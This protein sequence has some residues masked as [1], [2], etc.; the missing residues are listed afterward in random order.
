MKEIQ[1]K[2][3]RQ[4]HRGTEQAR[5]K[6][7]NV[8]EICKAI[9]HKYQST[10]VTNAFWKP[11]HFPKFRWDFPILDYIISFFWCK[12]RITRPV[13]YPR[14]VMTVLK[15]SPNLVVRK[16]KLRR[17]LQLYLERVSEFKK[18]LGYQ[19]KVFSR[20]LSFSLDVSLD[21]ILWLHLPNFG[22]WS[23]VL[24]ASQGSGIPSWSLCWSRPCFF[25]LTQFRIFWFLRYKVV[26]FPFSFK[27]HK[28]LKKDFVACMVML[29]H[30]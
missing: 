4:L 20:F 8:W 5:W 27:S 11:D 23:I 28:T 24:P 3:V 30:F 10:P 14:T 15:R 22:T 26:F 2:R 7:I 19:A 18:F 16:G 1:Q 25:R 9:I 21:F 6:W 13:E 29:C 17:W 12:L